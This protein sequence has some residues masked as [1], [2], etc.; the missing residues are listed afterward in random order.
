MRDV[1]CGQAAKQLDDLSQVEK[2]VDGLRLAVT[3]IDE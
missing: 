1:D 3:D 2:V